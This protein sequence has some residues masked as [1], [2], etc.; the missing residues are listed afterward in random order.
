MNFAGA[1]AALHDPDMECRAYLQHLHATT[2]LSDEELR[3]AYRTAMLAVHPDK[4][5]GDPRA[6]E[7]LSTYI[8][9]CNL[10]ARPPKRIN[11][12]MFHATCYTQTNS[13]QDR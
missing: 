6:S 12:P 7:A 13:N 2:A 5:P 8:D 11:T 1:G 9:I 10:H 4:H 3:W